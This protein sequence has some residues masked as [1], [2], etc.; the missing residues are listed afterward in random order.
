[1]SDFYTTY[2]S[3]AKWA[4]KRQQALARDSNQCQTCLSLDNLEVHHKTYERLGDEALEDLITLC[5][6]CHEAIT[7][8]IRRRRYEGK[9]ITIN[10]HQSITP[11]RNLKINHGLSK[12]TVST[13]ERRTDTTTQWSN[14]R[15]VEQIF[16]GIEENQWQTRQDGRGSRNDVKD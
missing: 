3:S 7:T 4:A 14:V 12:I 11:E 2:I 6:E 1:M 13:Y 5:H 8:V 9:T 15:S 16:Q 10:D